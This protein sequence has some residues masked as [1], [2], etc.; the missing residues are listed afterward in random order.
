MVDFDLTY[1]PYGET[2]ILI[3]WP[4]KID[5]AIIKDITAFEKLIAKEQK[6][7]AT[8]I[9]YNSILVNYE[10]MY[11]YETYYKHVNDFSNSVKR[12]KKM[13]AE[14]KITKKNNQKIWQ[15]P[16]CYD[17]KFGLD[18]EELS[19]IKNIPV[20]EIINLHT[21][22]SYLVY[23]LGFQ[24]GFMYLGGL[25]EKLHQ[26]RKPNPRLR[27]DKGCVGIGGKQT[28]IYP[29]D[30]SGGWNIIGKSPL[31][32]FNVSKPNP[33]FVKSGDKIQFTSISIDEFHD[34]ESQVKSDT[35]KIN[36]L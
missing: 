21:N 19:Q 10:F 20:E 8:T 30:S 33:C 32:F 31:T 11:N 9:A 27:V 28:G 24:P 18:L 13:Y 29:L 25:D 15:I 2:S 4:S 3:E 1:K 35:F 12:L 26:P 14:R 22:T 16:V 7:I 34:I 5:K 17:I 23:F 6:V 36:F